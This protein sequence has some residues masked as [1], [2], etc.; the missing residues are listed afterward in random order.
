MVV[1]DLVFKQTGL[2]YK[3]YVLSIRKRNSKTLKIKWKENH[4]EWTDYKSGEKVY[5]VDIL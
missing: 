1:I 4:I 2:W 5:G 3:Y